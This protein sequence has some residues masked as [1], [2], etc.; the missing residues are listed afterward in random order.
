MNQRI[1]IVTNEDS[2]TKILEPPLIVSLGPLPAG[3]KRG[4]GS[5][6]KKKS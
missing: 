2:E 5:A 3:G 4:N 1:V 6:R